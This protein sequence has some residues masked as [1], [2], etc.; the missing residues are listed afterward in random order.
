MDRKVFL[1]QGEENKS[2][3]GRGGV[4]LPPGRCHGLGRAVVEWAD[5]PGGQTGI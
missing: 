3:I 5:V 2:E 4:L 1:E